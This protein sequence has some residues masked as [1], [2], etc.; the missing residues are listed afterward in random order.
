ML[1]ILVRNDL[2]KKSI[3]TVHCAPPGFCAILA[4]QHEGHIILKPRGKEAAGGSVP[5]H[6]ADVLSR[7]ARHGPPAAPGQAFLGQVGD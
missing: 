3:A 4:L 7:G 1:F 5:S 6:G 2:S